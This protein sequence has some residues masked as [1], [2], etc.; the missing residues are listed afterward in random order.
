MGLMLGYRLSPLFQ[1]TVPASGTNQRFDKLKETLRFIEQEYVDPVQPDTLIRY[2]IEGM[3]EHLD[4]HSQYIP[5]EQY[6]M[7]NDPLAGNFE[8][9]G[10]QF[11]I[12]KDTVMVVQP[13]P[14]G[15]SEKVGLMAGDRIVTVDDSLIAG[16]GIDNAGAM[17]LLKGP[18]GSEVRVGVFR[19][20]VP[21][22]LSFTIIRDV[23]PTYSIDIAFMPDPGTGYIRISRFAA[24]T[25]EEFREAARDLLDQG[26]ERLIIDLRDN[27]GGFLGTAIRIADELLPEKKL[28]VYTEGYHQTREESFASRKGILEDIPLA[29]LVNGNSASASEI[30][31]GAIQD[32]DRGWIV[33]RRTYGKGL[34]QRQLDYPDGSAVRLT[35]ARYHTPSG[36]C[37]Q[38]PFDRTKGFDDYYAGPYH[39]NVDGEFVYSDSLTTTDTLTY[40]TDGG[41]K[42]YGGGGIKPDLI[43]PLDTAKEHQYFIR[44]F[45]RGLIFRFAFEYTDSH[46]QEL[47]R[48][49]DF[50]SFD[51]QFEVSPVLMQELVD[52]AGK[53]G[54]KA[55]GNDPGSSE[56]LIRNLLKA[57]IARNLF[58][59]EGFYPVW[60]RT[61]PVYRQAAQQ[62]LLQPEVVN[63]DSL[64]H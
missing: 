57:Y 18:K 50:E 20:G 36:R 54:L 51:K 33:G 60:L 64:T 5:A 19:R 63:N 39:R 14:G 47:N 16:T 28:I 25:D 31:A 15:P 32:H 41:R 27:T 3:L 1:G 45:N 10:I 21:N 48:F 30:L 29:V 22:L 9:I 11:R 2:G 53:Q 4:P 7:Q 26:M 55:S 12:E 44:L 49:S 46:R 52:Y 58:D 40:F 38:R 35:I 43:V 6:H 59:M 17:K 24:N 8:G 23:I 37:I 56:E 61:D 13:I 34:V 62:L 42:V